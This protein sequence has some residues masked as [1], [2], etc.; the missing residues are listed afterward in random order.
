M[1][2][3]YQTLGVDRNATPDEIKRAY[4]RLASQHH[5]DKGGD[6][7]K[8]QEI[9]QA[10]RTLS[11]PQKKSMHDNPNPFGGG[12]GQGMNNQS[13][14]FESI[15]D[16]F[17]TRFQHPHHQQRRA[18]HAIM[19]LW[20]TLRDIAQGGHKSISV[21]TQHGTT[22][23]QIEIPLGLNDGDNVQYSGV[24]PGGI[25]LVIT[26]R[27][28][29]DP[30]WDRQ[31][32]TLQTEHTVSVWDLIVGCETPIKDILGNNLSLTVPSGTQPGTT[33]RLRG[34]GLTARNGESGDLLVKIQAQIPTDIPQEL[35]DYIIQ[36]RGQ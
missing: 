8:F 20:L 15:F 25:D 24:G 1:T 27:I 16:I 9:E 18:Q 35:L 29:P 14:N 19:T 21:G 23:V 26:Y 12:F 32:L 5:P 10:Y 13:F 34:R 11:D 17:G 6:K 2:N 36:I 4:R 28:H 22:T 3:Y 33:L 30:K 31:G 7:N